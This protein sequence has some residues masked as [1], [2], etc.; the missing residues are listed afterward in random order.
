[1]GIIDRDWY[2]G[3]QKSPYKDDPTY[4]RGYES[5]TIKQRG[6]SKHRGLNMKLSSAIILALAIGYVIAVGYNVTTLHNNLRD[7][8]FGAKNEMAVAIEVG[9]RLGLVQS[10]GIIG[11]AIFSNDSIS[12]IILQNP[13]ILREYINVVYDWYAPIQW[14][15]VLS[16][17]K[18]IT[19]LRI[20]AGLDNSSSTSSPN[21]SDYAY[22]KSN[23]LNV[24]SGPSANNRVL[25]TL[26][27]NSR[28][29]VIN[30]AGAW[31]KIKYENIEG[32]VNSMYLR[33]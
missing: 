24:R 25:A 13:R 2:R 32:Y 31:W 22:V 19:W 16:V 12:Q 21:D 10:L 15:P 1:M 17:S 26:R 29:Q 20:K 6:R 3:E 8:K 23:A 9:S 4:G 14:S 30:K 7:E 11:N 28:V 18:E 33:N 5:S 27:M